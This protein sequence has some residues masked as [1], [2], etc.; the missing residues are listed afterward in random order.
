MRAPDEGGCAPHVLRQYAMLA[1]GERAALLGPHGHV[2]WLCAPA[3]HSDAVFSTLVG[4]RGCYSITPT[5]RHVWGGYYEEG[6]LIWRSR[7][8]TTNGVVECREALAFP[9][10]RDRLVLM[11]QV[12][13]LEGDADVEVRLDA[14]AGF[15][16]EPM[17]DLTHGDGSWTAT[18]GPLRLRWSGAGDQAQENDAG[19]LALDL[20]LPQGEHRDFVLELSTQDLP[21]EPPEPDTLWEATAY[22]WAQEVPD[23][24]E[25][26]TPGEARHAYAVLRGM[27]SSSGGMVAAATTSLPERAD[28]GRDYDYRY[29][30]IRDQALTGQAI[31][32]AGPH[33]LLDDAVR[34]VAARVLEHGARLAPAYTIDGDAVPDQRQL[35]LPGYP[36]GND[37]VGNHVNAQFQLDVFGEVL[38][39]FA[40]AAGH[41][42]L[43]AEGWRAASAAVDAIVERWH[44]S[45]AGF[46][47]LDPHQWTESRLICVAGL[48]AIAAA[49]APTSST[50]GWMALAD[51]ILA[52]TATTCTHESGRWQRAPDDPGVD[53]G[54][55][56]PA[57][58]G[59]IAADDPRTEATL[60]ALLDELA[61]DHHLYRFRQQPGPLADAEGSFLMCGFL[62][63]MA[64]QQQGRQ[65]EAYRWF[66]RNRAACGPPGLYS[67][68]YDIHQ[69]QLRG[70][71]PQAFVHAVMF[72][73]SIRLPDRP[74]Y[75][76]PDADTRG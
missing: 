27:T 46:W 3:W 66:E 1:D 50:G 72:E 29:V 59:G 15:G 68:E 60:S 8:T 4:G 38:L 45:E 25:S 17:G 71:L 42:R 39:L 9:G 36:G 73:A 2:A 76:R 65:V 53:A 52:D 20:H 12:V 32:A 58:R 41:D 35:D 26:A 56:L 23:V 11:R 64:L 43:D 69:R 54:L 18:T 22:A 34:F 6:S 24:A 51:E 28:Q 5:G 7:W 47:E 14:R 70:N 40:A 49:G 37:V 55:L 16:V 74:Q 57:L 44:E 48:R 63:A 62:M 10:E 13:A 67:E 21:D 31:A 19:E 61:D 33:P 75:P 30:W